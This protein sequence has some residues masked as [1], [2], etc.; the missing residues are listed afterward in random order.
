MAPPLIRKTLVREQGPAMPGGVTLCTSGSSL[1]VLNL[2]AGV[3][4]AAVAEITTI[5]AETIAGFANLRRLAVPPAYTYIDLF[6]I[7]P[8]IGGSAT[9]TFWLIGRMPDHRENPRELEGDPHSFAPTVVGDVYQSDGPGYWRQLLPVEGTGTVPA[10][11]FGFNQS[12]T[13]DYSGGAPWGTVNFRLRG[14]RTFF[15]A[16]CTELICGVSTTGAENGSL[17]VGQFNA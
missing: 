9:G 11:A 4:N 10:T 8:T 16:G 15:L 17:I 14:P 6:M 13:L 5:W 12:A 7:T 1:H 3:L 2:N